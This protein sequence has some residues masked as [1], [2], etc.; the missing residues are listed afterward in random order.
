MVQHLNTKRHIFNNEI[1]V[2]KNG[3]NWKPEGEFDCEC[4]K[5]YTNKSGLWKHK[6]V[7]KI[8]SINHQEEIVD[9]QT[10]I[11]EQQARLIELLEQNKNITKKQKVIT[12]INNNYSINTTNNNNQK[13]INVIAYVNQHFIDTKPI[14]QIKERDVLKILNFDESCGHSLEDMIVF[15][16]TKYLLDQFI[17]EFIVNVYKQKDPT[18]QQI[19][20]SNVKKLTFI[21]RQILNKTEKVWLKDFNGVCVTQHVISPI[22]EKIKKMMIKYGKKC[23]EEMN[24]PNIHEDRFNKLCENQSTSL[25]VIYDINQKKLHHKI[26]LYLAPH[27][28]L[29]SLKNIDNLIDF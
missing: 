16:H 9:K 10:I 5:Q 3:N 24:N 17:G 12:N 7:C 23:H 28:Q 21:V 13:T 11:L 14:Q 22:L 8:G 2:S 6:K 4:G 26:L 18:K 1:L 27:F 15:Q 29:V 20:S 25:K 19:W